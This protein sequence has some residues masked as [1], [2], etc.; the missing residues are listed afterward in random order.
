MLRV[1]QTVP[2]TD[3]T[4]RGVRDARWALRTLR[5]DRPYLWLVYLLLY[6][7]PWFYKEPTGLELLASA[8]GIFVFLVA[9]LV[10][11]ARD[12]TPAIWQVALYA[13]IGFALSPFGGVWS[14]FPIY[15]AAA[16]GQLRPPRRAAITLALLTLSVLLFGLAMQPFAQWLPAVVLVLMIGTAC[17]FQTELFVKNKALQQAQQNVHALAVTAERE[18][19]A[20]DLHDVLGHTLTLVSVKADLASKLSARDPQQAK[21]EMEEVRDA[22]RDALAQIRQ[23]VT[24]MHRPALAAELA[25]AQRNLA[26]ADVACVVDAPGLPLPEQ[27]DATAAMILRE[28]LTNVI[29][30]AA[31]TRCS[32]A[33]RR[34]SG[35]AILLTVE[36]DGLGGATL[37]EGNGIA[38]MRAR[39]AAQGGTLDVDQ[40]A[41]GRGTR[42]TVR[43]PTQIEAAT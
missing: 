24:G 1:V 43:F 28:A 35:G 7:L 12:E 17:F 16:A 8:V 10:R 29:R 31:A 19:I 38:G 33:I 20:R 27:L 3:E 22:A 25:L 23:A 41:A 6:P 15:G 4:A 34:E 42:L 21:R 32:V 14:V 40:A 37:R 30:H 26:A 5:P 11:W 36:D 9:Y 39:A 18:R 13:A 2:S